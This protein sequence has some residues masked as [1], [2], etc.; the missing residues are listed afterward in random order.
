MKTPD[1]LEQWEFNAE[2]AFSGIPWNVGFD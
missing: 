1:L 2:A